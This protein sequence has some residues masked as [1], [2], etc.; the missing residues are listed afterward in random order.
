MEQLLKGAYDLH[1]HFSPDVRPRK[2][3]EYD[4]A[5]RFNAIGMKGFALKSHFTPTAE[6]AYLINRQF[7]GFHAVG[8]I[9]LN[10][11]V[12]GINPIAV[13]CCARMGGKIIW[14]PTFDAAGDLARLRR[15]HP[16]LVDMQLKIEAKSGAPF[17]G[18]SIIDGQGKLLPAMHDI[19][20]IILEYDL[21]ICTAHVSHAEAFA[22]IKACRDKGIRKIVA[23]HTDWAGTFYSFDER[24]KIVELGAKLEF[25]YSTD[26]IPHDEMCRQILELGTENVIL[27]SD[28]GMIQMPDG[29]NF[30]AKQGP[31]PDEGLASFVQIMLNH[32]LKPEQVRQMI[33]TTP[34]WLVG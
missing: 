6:R 21:V 31:Y 20:D 17:T 10:S 23:T 27:S 5:R 24:K 25:C 32:G 33:V 15:H 14:L 1:I 16:E 26:G 30:K 12:G 9:A 18:I 7:P 29:A 4:V 3:D 28:L 13:E 22:L 11:T 19:L 8:G 34:A 2:A